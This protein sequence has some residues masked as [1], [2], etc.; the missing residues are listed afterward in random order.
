MTIAVIVSS[1]Q[2]VTIMT[3]SIMAAALEEIAEDLGIAVFEMQIAFSIFVLGL[4]FGPFLIGPLSETFGRKPVWIGSNFWY[5]LWN[6]LC[7]VGYSKGLMIAGRFLAGCGASCG[8]TVCLFY[9][10]LSGKH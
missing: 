3:T 1:S 5:I 9:R 8:I 7:P 10:K 4:A 2:L 6:S